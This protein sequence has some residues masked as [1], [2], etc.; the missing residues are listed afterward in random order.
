MNEKVANRRENYSGNINGREINIF[1]KSN[2]GM[3]NQESQSDN[4]DAFE[5]RIG[6][7]YTVVAIADGLGSCE[8]SHIGAR[9]AVGLLCD[10]IGNELLAYNEIDK[11][12]VRILCNRVVD[13]WKNSVG[14]DYG[15]YDTTLLFFAYTKEILLVGRIGDG[16][17]L[18]D[19]GGQYRNFSWKDKVFGNQTNSIGGMNAK[20]DFH[21]ELIR[22]FK[23]QDSIMA[24]LATDGIADDI[25]EKNQKKLVEYVKGKIIE[26]GF[27]EISIELDGWINNW[28]SVCNA[29]DK[30]LTV[31]NIRGIDDEQ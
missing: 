22:D 16:M 17:V 24:V 8:I 12:V 11:D 31:I 26:K 10:W 5:A 29:D 13:R 30:T 27:K 9:H 1:C 15:K 23:M 3:R 28:K 19:I 2:I 21:I 4:Q 14:E 6:V 20:D 7:E 25:D 18:L